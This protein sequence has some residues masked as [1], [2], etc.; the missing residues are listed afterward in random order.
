M[1]L[2]FH[3]EITLFCALLLNCIIEPRCMKVKL[4]LQKLQSEGKFHLDLCLI[5]KM[6][7]EEK[8]KLFVGVI[9]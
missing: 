5:T 9:L 7:I 3:L 4:V 8:K 1:Y 2:Y 6:H